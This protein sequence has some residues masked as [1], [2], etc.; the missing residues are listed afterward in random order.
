[1]HV[2]TPVFLSRG[3]SPSKSVFPFQFCSHE[4][5]DEIEAFFAPRV[6]PSFAMNVNQSLEILRIKARWADYVKQDAVL[7][8]VVSQLASQK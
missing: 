2:P 5:A 1:M 8:E 3:I 6:D 4:M 7:G